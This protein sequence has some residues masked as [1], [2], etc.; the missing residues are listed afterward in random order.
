M[1]YLKIYFNI[2]RKALISNRKKSKEIYY[3]RHHIKPISIGGPD[4]KKNCVLLTAREHFICH[5]L[6]AFY[7]KKNKRNSNKMKKAFNRMG[8]SSSNQKRYMNSH[9]YEIGKRYLY[10]PTSSVPNSMA[11]KKHTTETKLKMSNSAKG[12]PKS[13]E[14]KEKLRQANLGKVLSE[15]HRN[16][17]GEG[18][19]GRV[20]PMKD[21]KHSV[22]TKRKISN[23]QIGKKMRSESIEKSSASRKGQKRTEEMKEKMRV[24]FAKSK[25]YKC[26]HCELVTNKAALTKHL[27]KLYNQEGVSYGYSEFK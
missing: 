15:E 23:S 11:G 27:N 24:A 18:N 20:S 3:E 10:G 4:I 1:N 7:F 26:N 21:K 22:E 17:I 19:L 12:K 2:I 14:T 9:L 5:A 25:K 8:V 16:N 6:L 13:D